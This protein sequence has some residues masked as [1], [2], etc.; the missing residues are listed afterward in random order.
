MQCRWNAKLYARIQD[1]SVCPSSP[2]PFLQLVRAHILDTCTQWGLYAGLAAE[3]AVDL[4]VAVS[5][6]L[7]L[8]KF[9]TGI[10]R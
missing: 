2:P 10:R 1:F 8:R 7:L 4:I 9:Q 3:S 5:Q 6:C